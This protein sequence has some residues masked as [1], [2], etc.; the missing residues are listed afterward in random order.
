MIINMSVIDTKSNI[1]WRLLKYYPKYREIKYREIKME[2]IRDELFNF[3]KSKDLSV[4]IDVL[5]IRLKKSYQVQE[6]DTIYKSFTQTCRLEDY[7]SNTIIENL[8]R[9]IK[10]MI[11][12][13]IYR[14]LL[15]PSIFPEITEIDDL[16][17]DWILTLFNKK[18]STFSFGFVSL[19]LCSLY[20]EAVFG[21]LIKHKDDMLIKYDENLLE[22]RVIGSPVIVLFDKKDLPTHIFSFYYI[23]L[24]NAGSS[25]FESIVSFIVNDEE[26]IKLPSAFKFYMTRNEAH[27]GEHDSCYDFLFHDLV[28]HG[29]TVITSSLVYDY[30]AIRNVLSKL[31]KDT[32]TSRIVILYVFVCLYENSARQDYL[33]HDRSVNIFVD[34]HIHFSKLLESIDAFDHCLAFDYIMKCQPLDENFVDKDLIDRYNE[35]KIK[36]EPLPKILKQFVLRKIKVPIE[37]WGIIRY[38]MKIISDIFFASLYDFVK[39]KY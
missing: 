35:Y 29:D 10:L 15:F 2:I 3:C 9:P 1:I 25:S 31:V 30:S 36:Y 32:I 6:Y 8:N 34:F 7:N 21:G 17:M 12:C 4:C 38:E 28:E 13:Q 18:Y 33:E 22:L 39:R 26:M 23:L 24:H 16:K 20:S 27:G 37:E 14:H 19:Q 5:K 11:F